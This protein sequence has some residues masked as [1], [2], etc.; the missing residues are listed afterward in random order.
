MQTVLRILNEQISLECAPGD[1]RRLEDLAA[2]LEAR[3]AGFSGNEDGYRRLV[4]TA[5]ALLGESQAAGAAL[6]R[7]HH[8]IERLNDMVAEARLDQSPPPDDRRLVN[9][10]RA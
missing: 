6:M 3:L 9:A 7:A 5:I 10:L 4:L 8:E 1:Q 2:A